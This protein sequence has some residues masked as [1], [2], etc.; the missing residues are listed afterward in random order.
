MQITIMRTSVF[1]QRV[2][3]ALKQQAVANKCC[4]GDYIR[5]VLY[6]AFQ[7]TPKSSNNSSHRM[8]E[9]IANKNNTRSLTVNVDQ[10][11]Y[12]KYNIAGNMKLVN[13][14]LQKV[15]GVT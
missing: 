8:L 9:N 13:A 5:K 4:L 6:D 12:Y 15:A 10:T 14:I 1:D 11:F 7:Y 2:L 3:P